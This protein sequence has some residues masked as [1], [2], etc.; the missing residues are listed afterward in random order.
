MKEIWRYPVKGMAGERLDAGQLGEAGV[1][2]DRVWALWDVKRQEIQSCKVRPKLLRCTARTL[3]GGEH[4]EVTFPDG[5]TMTSEGDRAA[6]NARLS[7]L[8]GHESRLE[9]LRPASDV[10]FF[11]RYQPGWREDLVATFEREPGEPLPDFFDDFPEEAR[12]FIAAPG[13]FFLVTTLHVVT[14]ATLE[15][16]RSLT[17]ESDWDVR[18]FRPNVVIETPPGVEGLAEQHWIGQQLTLGE[19]TL[20]CP[21]TTPRCGATVRQQEGIPADSTV[22]RTIVKHADQNLGIY[23]ETATP[24]TVRRGDRVTLV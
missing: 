11:R 15:H 1:A 2:G 23:G 24:G 10:D 18:R 17:P 9:P 19:A 5:S 3:A 14:T 12:E 4:V 21:M 13:A 20:D 7:E 8:V 22:L 16:L 6:I